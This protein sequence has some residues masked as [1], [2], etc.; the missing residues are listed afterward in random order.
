MHL[1]ARDWVSYWDVV[2]PGLFKIYDRFDANYTDEAGYTHFYTACKYGY[3][4]VVEKFLELGQDPNCIVTETGDS[5]L[6][7]AL[8]CAEPGVVKLLLKHGAN[9]NLAD[10]EGQGQTS[11]YIICECNCCSDLMAIFEL[12]NDKYQPLQ[13]NAQDKFG[14]T[15]L[16]L[17]VAYGR[18]NLIECLLRN[19]ADPN[20]ANAYGST[21]LHISSQN[22][23]DNYDWLEV[24]F[25]VINEKH[26]LVQIDARDNFVFP[27][28][29]YFG[30]VK[31]LCEKLSRRFFRRYALDS[32]LDLTRYQL[33]ILCCEMIL[34]ESLI[35]KDLYHICLA[36]AGQII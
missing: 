6:H 13:V 35:N 2:V 22:R 4:D 36:A 1:A 24:F 34:D 20:L 31:H 25:K 12:S 16:H 11:L 15:P 27:T 33:P 8:T 5:P 19:G 10:A 30:V 26:Q 14:N 7:L 3:E 17:A 9:P 21:P 23:F 28:E 32:F 29:S 18:N